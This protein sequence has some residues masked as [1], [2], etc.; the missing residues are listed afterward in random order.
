MREPLERLVAWVKNHP[1]RTAATSTM[2][3]PILAAAA[4]AVV[5]GTSS[6]AWTITKAI[7]V[8]WHPFPAIAWIAVLPISGLG[9]RWIWERFR[10]PIEMPTN[11]RSRPVEVPVGQLQDRQTRSGLSEPQL[12]QRPEHLLGAG[13]YGQDTVFVCDQGCGFRFRRRRRSASHLGGCAARPWK[14]KPRG[15]RQ[16]RESPESRERNDSPTYQPKPAA[17]DRAKLAEPT[18]AEYRVGLIA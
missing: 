13:R 4:Q 14:T 1:W 5:A 18:D 8:G 6:Y 3:R 16:R 2:S 7:I 9:L 12:W 17:Q 10:H 15:N 11:L